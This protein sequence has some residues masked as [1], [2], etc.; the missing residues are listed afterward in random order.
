MRVNI[1]ASVLFGLLSFAIAT[2][3]QEGTLDSL[4]DTI[5]P[6]ASNH[7]TNL[8][9]RGKT[10]SPKPICEKKYGVCT[11]FSDI[12]CPIG[13]SCC[14]DRRCCGK[15]HHCVQS[16]DKGIRCRSNGHNLLKVPLISTTMRFNIPITILFGLL[17]LAAATP[18]GEG[19]LKAH[20]GDAPTRTTDSVSLA[21]NGGSFS[22]ELGDKH[23]IACPDAVA[24]LDFIVTGPS[25]ASAVAPMASL[26]A[27]GA[28]SRLM[29]RLKNER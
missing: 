16:F 17:P 10:S 14:A 20:A 6:I 15:G 19:D 12:C 27:S 4:V 7:G 1:L 18:V 25:T 24:A 3:V 23:K 26:A 5:D 29:T 21:A 2:P 13:G 28:A 9:A 11:N 8:L 22:T